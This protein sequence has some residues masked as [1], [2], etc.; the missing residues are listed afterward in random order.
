VTEGRTAALL[1]SAVDAA[2]AGVVEAALRAAVE[3]MSCVVL[4]RCWLL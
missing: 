4:C 1:A 3:A 2:A